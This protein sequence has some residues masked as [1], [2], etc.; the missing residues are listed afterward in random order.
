M[1]WNRRERT[2]RSKNQ[3]RGRWLRTLV[4]ASITAVAIG[5]ANGAFASDN[6]WLVMRVDVG[7]VKPDEAEASTK[8]P[9]LLRSRG[10]DVLDG[11][12]A[13]SEL[14]R[15][16]SRTP[17]ALSDKQ[18]AE[19]DGSLR[20]LA[21]ELSSENLERAQELQA[22]IDALSPDIRDQLNHETQRAR[23]RFHICL[24]TA[25]LFS[26][27]GY[28]NEASEQVRKCARDFPGLEPE[29]GP[30]LPDTIRKFFAHAHE[31]LDRIRPSSVHVDLE[32]YAS[33]DCR[34]RLNGIDRGP[35]PATVDEVRTQRVRIQVDCGQQAGRIYEVALQPGDNSF[36]IDPELDRA[37]QPAPALGLKYVDAQGANNSRLLHSLRIA[38]AVGAAYVLQIYNGELHRIDVDTRR[39]TIVGELATPLDQLVD[40]TLT[41]P[42]APHDAQPNLFSASTSD[43]PSTPFATLGWI[44]AGAAVLTGVGVIVAW[45]VREGDVSKF[46]QED[47]CISR[48]AAATEQPVKC[49]GF[50]EDAESAQNAMK[51]LG[52]TG[53]GFAAL[54]ATFFVLDATSHAKPEEPAARSCG[55]GPG[56]LGVA[57]RMQF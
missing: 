53:I 25:H 38:R 20:K 55:P 17:R 3:T 40:S 36:R 43:R 21:D 41:T 12:G 4:G 54:A 1:L 56:E 35:T 49:P 52:F 2:L 29:Q 15:R 24:L 37:V 7:A 46:N 27:E 9:Q 47:L 23:R 14:E 26:K 11:P 31:E 19:L 44:S 22:E 42:E 18:S 51:I 8:L 34:A 45:R 30:Y 6:L 13:S 50:L 10:L 5:N 57:C 16:H 33:K 32:N 48:F 39:D 28:Q